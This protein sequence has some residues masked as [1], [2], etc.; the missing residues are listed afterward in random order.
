MLRLPESIFYA[1][2]LKANVVYFD[3]KPLSKNP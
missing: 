3:N 2:G 1:N